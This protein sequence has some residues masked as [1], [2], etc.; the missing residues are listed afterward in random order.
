MYLFFVCTIKLNS[1][2]WQRPFPDSYTRG[3]YQDVTI[4]EIF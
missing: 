1:I 4:P 2:Q 3:V